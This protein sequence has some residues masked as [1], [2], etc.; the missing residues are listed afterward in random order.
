MHTK[1][2]FVCQ[3]IRQV[4]I[5]L[6][7]HNFEYNQEVARVE[8]SGIYDMVVLLAKNLKSGRKKHPSWCFFSRIVRTY[9]LLYYRYSREKLCSQLLDCGL[10]PQKPKHVIFRRRDQAYAWWNLLCSPQILGSKISKS[11]GKLKILRDVC[12][13][14]Y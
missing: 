6:G 9:V 11:V 8:G 4:F 5:V 12:D 3:T 14:F 2:H 10:L 1:P 13:R 7:I